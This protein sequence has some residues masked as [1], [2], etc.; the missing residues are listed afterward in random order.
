MRQSIR[1]T[2]RVKPV[3][4]TPRPAAP[5]G[6][7]VFSRYRRFEPSPA[8]R[9][10]AAREFGSRDDEYTEEDLAAMEDMAQQARWESLCEM[11]EAGERCACCG[12]RESDGFAIDRPTGLCLACL[13]GAEA[14]TEQSQWLAAIGRL[15]SF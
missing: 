2:P 14:A 7:G 11:I 8:D 4:H 12:L 3:R 5:F 10:W 6:E 13:A 9:E 1:P 15:V